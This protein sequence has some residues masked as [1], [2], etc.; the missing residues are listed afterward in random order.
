MVA[1]RVSPA[2]YGP[3][4]DNLYTIGTN[5]AALPTGSAGVN[6]TNLAVLPL[7]GPIPARK[8]A[9]HPSTLCVLANT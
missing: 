5:M 6:N 7:A 2:H 4:L 9:R 3:N 1:T 8:V